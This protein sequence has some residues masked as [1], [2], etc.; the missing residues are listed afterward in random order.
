MLDIP[1]T[2][3]EMINKMFERNNREST[4]RSRA[5]KQT[6][7]LSMLGM[8]LI[9]LGIIF[10]DDRLIGYSFMGAGVLLSVID[11]IKNRST[12]NRGVQR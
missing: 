3:L 6:S 5:Q 12:N 2:M 1:N 4:D 7:Q 10:G 9:T 11:A 8:S